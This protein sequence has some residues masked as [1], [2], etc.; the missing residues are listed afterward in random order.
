MN[1]VT[2]EIEKAKNLRNKAIRVMSKHGTE[3]ALIKLILTDSTKFVKL[4]MT[5]P[6]DKSLTFRKIYKR[7][8]F[9]YKG[10]QYEIYLLNP[11]IN[12]KDR[13]LLF[14]NDELVFVTKYWQRYTSPPPRPTLEWFSSD[15]ITLK[16]D[17]WIEDI[18][19]IMKEEEQLMYENNQ[20][21]EAKEIEDNFDLG[22]YS[23]LEED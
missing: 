20:I 21:N 2:M 10:D 15:I 22:K 16:L 6:P 18:P 23:E 8:C 5:S 14:F 13:L 11:D 19:K 3:E 4:K 9:E 12:S 7:L 1:E 17:D